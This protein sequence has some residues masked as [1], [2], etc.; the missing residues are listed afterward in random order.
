MRISP[1]FLQWSSRLAWIIGSCGILSLSF[2]FVTVPPSGRQRVQSSSHIAIDMPA[3][4]GTPV[5]AVQPGRVRFSG[6]MRGYGNLIVI[7]H[8][9]SLETWYAHLSRR[10][11][12][13]GAIVTGEARIGL[14]GSTG[15]STG[16][17]LH[18]EIRQ[19]GRRILPRTFP[20]PLPRLGGKDNGT[21]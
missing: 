3:R 16:P 12:E 21:E 7:Q 20:W 17:H 10:L 18:Y 13:V 9:E 5:H 2:G 6:W 4:M 14:I 1:F 15:R 19:H 11:V 8:E